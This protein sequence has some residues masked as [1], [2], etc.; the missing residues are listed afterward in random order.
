MAVDANGYMGAI[1]KATADVAVTGTAAVTQEDSVREMQGKEGENLRTIAVDGAGQIIMVPRGA[2]GNYLGVDDAGYMTTVIKGA[3]GALLKTLATDDDGNLV[4]LLTDAG[5]Q[6]GK[7]ATVGIGELAARL[8][9]PVSWDRRGQVVQMTTFEDG[10]SHAFPAASGGEGLAELCPSAYQTGGYSCKLTT[11]AAVDGWASVITYTDFSPSS[12]VG[13]EV[14]FSIESQPDDI[15]FHCKIYDGTWEHFAYA[16]LHR[17]TNKLQI[18][19]S[20]PVYTDVCSYYQHPAAQLFY[21]IKF[22]IDTSA[23]RWVRVLA[24]GTEFDKSAVVSYRAGGGAAPYITLKV[25]AVEAAGVSHT[26]YVDRMIIT[27]NEP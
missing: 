18:Y 1:L 5:D 10:F 4:A 9:S 25:K 11:E 8:G 23:Q 17:V 15:Q 27:T 3:Y 13:F 20:T 2:S 14:V 12:R 24:V 19:N 21:S 16:Q 26:I 6:W 7:K 22:V